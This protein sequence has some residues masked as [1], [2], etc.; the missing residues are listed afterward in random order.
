MFRVPGHL[1]FSNVRAPEFP[2]YILGA[3]LIRRSPIAPLIP[4]MGISCVA[5]TMEKFMRMS[6][7]ADAKSVPDVEDLANFAVDAFEEI[8]AAFPDAEFPPSD[9]ATK[10]IKADPKPA[11][12]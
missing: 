3:K 1:Y 11:D 6:F 8:R 12:V 2:L 10:V 4:V 7:S 5:I 9:V